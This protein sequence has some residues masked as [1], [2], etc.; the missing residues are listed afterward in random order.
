MTFRHSLLSG[1]RQAAHRPNVPQNRANS[2][3][4]TLG[5]YRPSAIM[6]ADVGVGRDLREAILHGEVAKPPVPRARGAFASCLRLAVALVL[7]ALCLS[8]VSAQDRGAPPKLDPAP[9]RAD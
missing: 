8:S 1:P 2:L 4:R 5:F 6:A 7:A 9:K 3:I